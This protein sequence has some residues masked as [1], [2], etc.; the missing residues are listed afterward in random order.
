[1]AKDSR[2]QL[3]DS[4]P[5]TNEAD[6]SKPRKGKPLGQFAANIRTGNAMRSVKVADAT[7]DS[8]PRA[9][10]T[11]NLDSYERQFARGN[12]IRAQSRNLCHEIW[13]RIIGE[14]NESLKRPTV[15]SDS[16]E[17]QRFIGFSLREL[18]TGRTEFSRDY[19]LFILQARESTLTRLHIRFQRGNSF[20]SFR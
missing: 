19:S 15:A 9:W 14:R 8:P 17:H 13:S 11:R 20:L 12:E 10:G 6:G 16:G 7:A 3:R 1:M 5:D 4:L 2:D 18:V